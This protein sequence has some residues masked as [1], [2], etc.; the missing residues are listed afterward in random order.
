MT[1]E[2]V[3][4]GTKTEGGEGGAVYSG[5]G[6]WDVTKKGKPRVR[7]HGGRTSRE[8]KR[9]AESNPAEWAKETLRFE[10]DEAQWRALASISKRGLLNCT[11]Q[12]GKSTVTAIKAVHQAW[13]EAGSLTLVVSPSGRQ[14]SEFVRKAAGFARKL[15]APVRG[16]GDNEISLEFANK[17]RIVG[18]P[19]NEATA[20]GFSA[21]SLLLVDEAAR[22]SD[23]LYKAI[24]PMLAVSGGGLW[25]MSTPYGK[26]GFFW[27]AWEHGGADWERIQVPATECGRIPRE[28]LEEERR[29]MG[30][31][32][33]RQEYLCEF[34]DTVSG[35]FDRDLV[36]RAVTDAF[37]PLR[38]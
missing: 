6:M 35:V 9:R 14:S 18:L 28:F 33:F 23:D 27:E 19:G 8:A 26:R 22:V 11:R 2:R 25:L 3:I 17:S 12:W 13:T 5:I 10:A 32:W 20:R 38:L 4:Q 36:E 31:A 15:G 30:D 21:V 7:G 16:D 24:R 34:V 1:C 37:E 29:T